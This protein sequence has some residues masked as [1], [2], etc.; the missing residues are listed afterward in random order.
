MC[1]ILTQKKNHKAKEK[2]KEA[3]GKK[4]KKSKKQS[5]ERKRAKRKEEERR[6]S[7]RQEVRKLLKKQYR[8][9]PLRQLQ[10][11]RI[12]IAVK[13]YKDPRIPL[14]D[15]YI[16]RR[17]DEAKKI[18]KATKKLAE[19]KEYLRRHPRELEEWIEAKTKSRKRKRSE[20]KGDAGREVKE[21]KGDSGREVKERK[22]DAGREVKERKRDPVLD[23]FDEDFAPINVASGTVLRTL[24]PG[25]SLDFDEQK[26]LLALNDNRLEVGVTY[27]SS[28]GTVAELFMT[29][30]GS[31]NQKQQALS[32]MLD[33]AWWHVM[34]MDWDLGV[35][36]DKIRM[37]R[38]AS[39]ITGITIST[40]EDP[41]RVAR[42]GQQ[43]AK[44]PFELPGDFLE[45]AEDLAEA[46][47]YV[48]GTEE[49]IPRDTVQCLIYTFITFGF[50]RDEIEAVCNSHLVKRLKSGWERSTSLNAESALQDLANYFHVDIMFQYVRSTGNKTSNP[51]DG[52]ALKIQPKLIKANGGAEGKEPLYVG[53]Y[54]NHV[55]NNKLISATML[56]LKDPQTCSQIANK[57]NRRARDVYHKKPQ[58][59]DTPRRVLSL[60]NILDD[61]YK[62]TLETTQ[63]VINSAEHEQRVQRLTKVLD[64]KPVKHQQEYVAEEEDAVP[65]RKSKKCKQTT[66]RTF[67]AIDIEAD[68]QAED[69]EH[70]AILVGFRE[71]PKASLGNT[72]LV[73]IP[74]A[75]FHF[76]YSV[77]NMLK[78]I[79]AMVKNQ[80]IDDAPV[81]TLEAKKIAESEGRVY[82]GG[83]K[84]QK[85]I[86]HE[87][88]LFAH[89]AKYDFSLMK[90]SI[91]KI[92]NIISKSVSTLYGVQ[93]T[94]SN[95]IFTLKDSYKYMNW[96]LK[97]TAKK[98][99][100]NEEKYA[101]VEYAAYSFF[102]A[103]KVRPGAPP[104]PLT[105]YLTCYNRQNTSQHLTADEFIANTDSCFWY[106]DENDVL[107]FKARNYYVYYLKLDVEIVRQG[108]LE[109]DRVLTNDLGAELQG[110]VVPSLFERNIFTIP[111]LA[112]AFFIDNGALDDSYQVC[113]QLKEF[114]HESFYGGRVIS[115]CVS[116]SVPVSYEDACSLYPSAM[117][118]S[119]KELGGIVRG[120]CKLIQDHE[121]NI[122]F[123]STVQYYLV[124]VRVTGM[125]KKQSCQVGVIPE[126]R[127]NKVIYHWQWEG[128]EFTGV[129]GK[130]MLE[131]AID[132]LGL[133]YEILEG[134]YWNTPGPENH[135]Y[136]TLTKQLY[137]IRVQ[138][139]KSKP[140]LAEVIKL[141]LN[142]GTYGCLARKPCY[143]KSVCKKKNEAKQYIANN[144][145]E[146]QRW[147]PISKHITLFERTCIDKNYTSV[148]TA[149][150]VLDTSKKI[151]N[152]V[153]TAC[154]QAGVIIPYSDTDSF[155]IPQDKLQEV[156]TRYEQNTGL[157]YQGTKLGQFHSDFSIPKG[158]PTNT[159]QSDVVST[160]FYNLGKK[161]YYHATSTIDSLTGQVF[162]G[163][164]MSCKGFTK[165][166]MV[167][168]AQQEFKQPDERLALQELFKAVDNGAEYEINLFPTRES[169]INFNTNL[170]A[171]SVCNT[172]VP[173]TRTL[174]KTGQQRENSEDEEEDDEASILFS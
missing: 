105:D 141:I 137:D 18:E 60:L 82:E 81:L 114:T 50:P 72:G 88:T 117:V 23:D 89:N 1:S 107:M 119:I 13:N 164:K 134:V 42:S 12:D 49:K 99:G 90:D 19:A 20:K 4:S 39:R 87:V 6:E 98:L 29:L 64:Q 61:K 127:D 143:T 57:M 131:D 16:D 168:F 118:E 31:G 47:I 63:K 162:Q 59:R 146:L 130:I 104:V 103:E 161:L 148:V 76:F 165:Q 115:N 35:D 45:L 125:T 15:K 83:K 71:I 95:V 111:G 34:H 70:K 17:R 3:M 79:A 132:I 120:E 46:Q 5:R 67:Y 102:N 139:K 27:T 96:P 7:Q 142:S 54:D 52:K 33:G 112:R 68:I 155:V 2:K 149:C 84:N 51:S 80:L 73:D 126:R 37:L 36:S 28:D 10:A 160:Q 92:T 121:K 24:V 113:G 48:Q 55:F 157:V 14:L 11:K 110:C 144:F 123:L 156:I 151:M 86:R 173:F 122:E 169:R 58:F 101:K 41:T 30:T 138:Y 69:R 91:Q 74:E 32:Q 153:F 145:D 167:H 93:F 174:K 106:V 8:N 25:T 170:V 158:A 40:V 65:E 147:R 133:Q 163:Y 116:S 62:I 78:A 97:D 38:S 172:E 159:S 150:I 77:W 26:A 43:V 53:A 171:S 85:Y 66:L 94:F 9:L 124:R 21:R 129:Y 135:T 109:M 56:Y 152:R 108:L 44:C 100:L 154:S 22:G 136:S 75:D 166:G 128:K 140:A